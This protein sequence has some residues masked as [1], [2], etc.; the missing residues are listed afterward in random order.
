[1]SNGVPGPTNLDLEAH[2]IIQAHIVMTT[3]A[4][5]TAEGAP[6]EFASQIAQAIFA[7]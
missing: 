4:L 5:L 2:R 3:G 1:M 6:D 7:N